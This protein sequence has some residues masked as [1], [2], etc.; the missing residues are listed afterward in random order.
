[1]TANLKTVTASKAD[2]EREMA[3]RKAA[4]EALRDSE[5]KYRSLFE[6]HVGW[7]RLLQDALR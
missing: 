7:V 1:M 4:E 6:E 3:D 5:K 2:L